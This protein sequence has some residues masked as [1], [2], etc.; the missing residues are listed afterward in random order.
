MSINGSGD[1]IR[2]DGLQVM[3]LTSFLTAP[4]RSM[5]LIYLKKDIDVNNFCYYSQVVIK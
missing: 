4:P 3:S 2:T 5:L 1:P